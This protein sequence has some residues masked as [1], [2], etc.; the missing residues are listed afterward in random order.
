MLRPN[1]SLTVDAKSHLCDT[2]R[3]TWKY[4]ADRKVHFQCSTQKK[5]VWVVL[6]TKKHFQSSF[7]LKC[8][9][10]MSVLYYDVCLILIFLKQSRYHA[11]VKVSHKCESITP[12]WYYELGRDFWKWKICLCLKGEQTL[13]TLV[14]NWVVSIKVITEI[15]LVLDFWKFW[16]FGHMKYTKCIQTL[17]DTYLPTH[18]Y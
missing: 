2:I 5:Y 6:S 10:I 16:T 8:Q 7:S 3:K 4:H 12:T 15:I 13:I 1:S 18:T 14:I 17:H 9:S 11:Y